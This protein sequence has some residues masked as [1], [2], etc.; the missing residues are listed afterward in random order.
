MLCRSKFR[1]ALLH[2]EPE[3]LH[4]YRDPATQI[5]LLDRLAG[6]TAAASAFA[7]DLAC[8]QATEAE[9]RALDALGDEAARE[10]L[11]QLVDKV[12]R[13]H[14]LAPASAHLASVLFA[15]RPL[16]FPLIFEAL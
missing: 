6:T 14:C 8:L 1:P 9:L 2:A 16:A 10:D 7:R 3:F 12:K 11:Q 15:K 13:L 4:F 5:D